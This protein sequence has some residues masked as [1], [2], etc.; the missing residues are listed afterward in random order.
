MKLENVKRL[1]KQFKKENYEDLFGAL[2]IFEMTEN[3]FM[4]E[5]DELLES[6]LL[7]LK[8]MY[9]EFMEN[10]NIFSLLN[11]DLREIVRK[12]LK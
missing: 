6:D 1:A 8:K 9:N 12:V 11:E 5:I 2:I 7:D 3:D 4:Y 10:D